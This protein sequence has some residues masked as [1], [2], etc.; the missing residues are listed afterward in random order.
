MIIERFKM[1]ART[2]YVIL[3][4]AIQ[5]LK[6]FDDS[7]SVCVTQKCVAHAECRNTGQSRYHHKCSSKITTVVLHTRIGIT[8]TRVLDELGDGQTHLHHYSGKRRFPQNHPLRMELREWPRQQNDAERLLLHNI[9][10][11]YKAYFKR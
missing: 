1:E 10:W 8:P 11:T 9:L 4:K 6:C 5:K 2:L 3:V 7:S